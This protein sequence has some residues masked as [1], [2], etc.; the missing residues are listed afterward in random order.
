MCSRAVILAGG[1]GTRLL[2]YTTVLPKPLVPIGEY[3]V[4]EI[5]VRQLRRAGVKRLTLAVNH[6]ANLIQAFFGDG[7][8]WNLEIDYSLEDVPLSTV[9]PLRLI[10]DLPDTFLLMNGDVL[11]DLD[12]A[13]L[14]RS[15]RES[16]RL[17]TVAATTRR[18]TIDY[19]VLEI[20]AAGRTL[21]GF[22]EKPTAAYDV[23]MGIY[24]VQRD[25]VAMIPPDRAYGFDHLMV[26]LLGRGDRVNVYRH[27]GYWVD[28]GRPD[29]YA[30]A[31]EEFERNRERLL[32][33]D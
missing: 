29:D 32:P 8:S 21:T 19:G 17:F 9:A 20:D 14:C 4:L 30:Q 5:I 31:T 13:A 27:D 22:K 23:S 6:H 3:P 28:I 24:V 26:D 25:V 10:P 12:Y 18:H 11:T 1:R 16:G 15:H 2:P 7:A 33:D